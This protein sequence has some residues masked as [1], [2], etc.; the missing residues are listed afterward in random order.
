M[1]SGLTALSAPEGHQ[2][3][4]CYG[5]GQSHYVSVTFALEYGLGFKSRNQHETGIFR[6]EST[7]LSSLSA[8]CLGSRNG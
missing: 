6:F 2:V 3:G 7:W 5:L 4:F 1:G 8:I